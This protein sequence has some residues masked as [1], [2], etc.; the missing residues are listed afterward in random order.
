[1]YPFFAS[2]VLVAACFVVGAGVDAAVTSTLE[3]HDSPHLPL[4]RGIS[5]PLVTQWVSVD[6][7]VRPDDIRKR[8][9]QDVG[10]DEKNDEGFDNWSYSYDTQEEDDGEKILFPPPPPPPKEAVAQPCPFPYSHIKGFRT[11]SAL[12]AALGYASDV[13]YYCLAAAEE[14]GGIS[15]SRRIVFDGDGGD[16][17]ER[18]V[19]TIC[20][21]AVLNGRTTREILGL[22]FYALAELTS[23]VHEQM[24]NVLMSLWW[25]D[26]GEQATPPSGNGGVDGGLPAPVDFNL[27]RIQQ[28]TRRKLREVGAVGGLFGGTASA[29]TVGSAAIARFSEDASHEPK[30][31][32]YDVGAG[33]VQIDSPGVVL[34]CDHCVIDGRESHLIFGPHAS[35]V[36]ISGVTFVGGQLGASASI[37]DVGWDT[38]GTEGDQ[39]KTDGAE[40]EEVGGS[41]GTEGKEG[42]EG[43][44]KFTTSVLFEDCTWAFSSDSRPSAEMARRRAS[45]LS[46]PKRER[47]LYV[48]GGVLDINPPKGSQANVSFMR[49]GIIDLTTTKDRSGW[50]EDD[51]KPH[52][53]D[54]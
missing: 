45:M 16:E 7:E 49:C 13:H 36:R 38:G 54:G 44:T 39:P 29:G 32:R 28:R 27:I 50:V 14:M 8:K 18:D 4:V 6:D 15:D 21:G 10:T 17:R 1:M 42:I 20:P 52:F 22:A 23:G 24:S 11:L 40:K 46:G 53:S 47:E 51:F 9:K 37:R 30:H 26:F 12:R 31:A 25:G 3:L 34:E 33:P 43:H 5:E 2:V 48:Q 41:V 19:F 35:D